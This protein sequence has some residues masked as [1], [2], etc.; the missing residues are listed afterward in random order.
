MKYL[1]NNDREKDLNERDK[2]TVQILITFLSHVEIRRFEFLLNFISYD[3]PINHLIV[4][5]QII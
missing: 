4:R 5:A 1:E 2:K 3:F